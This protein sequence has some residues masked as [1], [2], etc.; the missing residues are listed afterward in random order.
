MKIRE[1]GE[2][3]AS[4]APSVKLMDPSKTRLTGERAYKWAD[5]PCERGQGRGEQGNRTDGYHMT[6]ALLAK[7][8]PR[9]SYDDGRSHFSQVGSLEGC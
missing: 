9:D 4:K 8:T 6:K 5:R 2:R 3:A 1:R 7:G